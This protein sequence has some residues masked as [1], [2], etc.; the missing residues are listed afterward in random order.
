MMWNYLVSGLLVES[1]IVLF[2]GDPTFPDLTTL[3]R[4]AAETR[5]TYLGTSAA[6]LTA[7]RKAAVRP[8]H[9][10]D[11]SSVRG[12]GST[13]A[14]LSADGFRW[15]Y[16]A[17]GPTVHL[18]SLSGGTD[19][20]TGFVG[21]CPLVPVWAGEISCRMLGARVEAFDSAGRPL[22]GSEG[23]LV[24][25]APMPSMP[26]GMWGDADGARY[27]AAY[28]ERYPGAWHHGDWI[29]LTDRGSC[30]ISGRSDATLNRGGV[31]QGTGEVYAVVESLPEVADSL[32]I[33]LEADDGGPGDLI[34]FVVVA[35]GAPDTRGL[36]DRIARAL[37]ERLSPR[38]APDRIVV[39]GSILGRYPA[40]SSRFP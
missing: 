9:D 36:D 1:T 28:F 21:P 31:R 27:R 26:I 8:G 10:L 37:R 38:C 11:L 19:L 18:G 23:E 17:L 33:H 14:P 2:D 34:L 4:L 6:F 32:V 24:I 13:G 40:R 5:T 39:V 12:V 25:T 20:C 16:E 3:W 35:R 15:V 30:I 22:Q 7:C 29:T